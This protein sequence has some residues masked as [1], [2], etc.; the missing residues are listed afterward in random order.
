MPCHVKAAYYYNILLDKFKLGQKYEKISSGDKVRYFYLAQPNKYNIQ[1]IGYKYYYPE[2]FKKLFE[3]DYETMFESHRPK[4]WVFGHYHISK[5]FEMFG[6][7]FTCV[8][9]LGVYD[10]DTGD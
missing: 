10:L 2:E 9:E 5:S 4:E 1:A 7:K 3:A 8:P 6:T